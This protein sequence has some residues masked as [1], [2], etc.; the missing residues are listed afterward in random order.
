[1]TQS[2]FLKQPVAAA[3]ING[4]PLTLPVPVNG[5]Q[6]RQAVFISGGGNDFAG[7]NDLRPL[8]KDDCSKFKTAAACY[9][10]GDDERTLGWLMKKIAEQKW[11]PVLSAQGLA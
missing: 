6:V 9:R 4:D 2:F 5:T 3:S 8:L 11:Q 7:Y 1:M 10:P